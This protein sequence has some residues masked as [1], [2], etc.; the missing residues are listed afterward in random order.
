MLDPRNSIQLGRFG[1]WVEP[2]Q[3]TF[4]SGKTVVIDTCTLRFKKWEGEPIFNNYGGKGVVDWE[5]E[6]TFAELAV[7]RL[8]GHAG[9]GGVWVDTFHRKFHQSMSAFLT[10]LGKEAKARLDAQEGDVPEHL[11]EMYTR[12]VS[13]NA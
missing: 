7:V 10:A 1:N 11:R 13:A 4:A 3:F 12:I 6:P 9:F 8:I 2:K 5:G